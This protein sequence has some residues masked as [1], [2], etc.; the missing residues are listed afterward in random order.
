MEQGWP[1]GRQ[2]SGIGLVAGS[3]A[4]S[5]CNQAT[6]DDL[7]GPFPCWARRDRRHARRQPRS[8]LGCAGW[9]C[10][11]ACLLGYFLH[12]A[13]LALMRV[14]SRLALGCVSL[15]GQHCCREHYPATHCHAVCPATHCYTVCPPSCRQ[16]PILAI[17]PI[18]H[19]APALFAE[20]AFPR[21]RSVPLPCVRP[22][23]QRP[24]CR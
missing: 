7:D 4:H 23:A 12:G 18:L 5:S 1:G 19:P 21:S 11:D 9:Q 17:P 24:A 20:L 14:S 10:A 22:M 13:S 16:L 6:G 8:R 3:S 2:H 15:P